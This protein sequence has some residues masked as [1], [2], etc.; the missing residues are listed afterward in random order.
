MWEGKD[1]ME[2]ERQRR[3]MRERVGEDWSREEKGNGKK[4][5]MEKGR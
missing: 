4:R 2:G 5:L 3:R 1:Y